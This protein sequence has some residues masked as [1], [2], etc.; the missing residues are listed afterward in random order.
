MVTALSTKLKRGEQ[1]MKVEN[2]IFASSS[3]ICSLIFAAIA[4]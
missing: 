2:A 3:W 4:I 1:T